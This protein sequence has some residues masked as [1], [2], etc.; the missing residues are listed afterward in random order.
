MKNTLVYQSLFFALTTLLS[1]TA[2]ADAL[3]YTS[4]HGDIGL[5]FHDEGDG[6][7]LE[8]HWHFDG[9]G[10]LGGMTADSLPGFDSEEGIEFEPNE[11]NVRVAD[12]PGTTLF[13]PTNT[14]GYLGNAPN[15]SVWV[16]P[17]D[18]ET[19]VP[20]LSLAGE[21]LSNALFSDARLFLTGL[22]GPVGG[23]VAVGQAA[24]LS[25]PETIF[26]QSNNG[27]SADDVIDIGA[28][29][30]AH[31]HFFYAFSQPG[32]YDLEI[33]A[34]ADRIGATTLTDTASFRFLVGSATAIPE[35]ASF[36]ILGLAS[37][38]LAF[39]RR[40]KVTDL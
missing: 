5:A 34:E 14:L 16:L 12:V 23:E 19:G 37:G 22:S 1:T 32:I 39:G 25:Q 40:R 26:W 24:A 29:P 38:C 21:E 10:V 9:S 7:E 18:N 17:Q 28:G 31:D 36:A 33:T 13:T 20:F 2:S 11:V 35:P 3:E 4:G 30:G 15:A 8:L 6:P 27:L